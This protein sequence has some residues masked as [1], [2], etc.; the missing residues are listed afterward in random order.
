MQDDDDVE[1]EDEPDSQDWHTT[2]ND[3]VLKPY[4]DEQFHIRFKFQ[5]QARFMFGVLM[6]K[7]EDGSVVGK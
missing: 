2:A 6:T 3:T 7:L 5:E 4:K 1:E